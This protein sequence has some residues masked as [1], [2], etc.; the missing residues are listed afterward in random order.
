M[1]ASA[2]PGTLRCVS[3]YDALIAGLGTF[4]AVVQTRY[5]RV[6]FDSV[7]VHTDGADRF[8][9]DVRLGSASGGD[10]HFRI[11]NP[12]LLVQSDRGNVHLG[13][14]RYSVD[15]IQAVAEVIAGHGGLSKGSG[16]RSP[17]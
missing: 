6:D 9:L 10:C 15:P 11:F 4:P 8:W 14:R 2:D 13:Q 7:Q 12:P 16:R 3:S 5:G 1:R 17:Q